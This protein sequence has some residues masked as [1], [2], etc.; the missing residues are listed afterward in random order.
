ME[1]SNPISTSSSPSL[2]SQ[3]VT[4]DGAFRANK[5]QFNGDSLP[6]WVGAGN[7]SENLGRS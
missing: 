7:G 6:T 1:T 5:R 3:L 2:T 4:E